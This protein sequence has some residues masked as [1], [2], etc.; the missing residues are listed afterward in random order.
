MKVNNM[1]VDKNIIVLIGLL[2][3]FYITF[4]LPNLNNRVLNLLTKPFVLL[5][6]FLITLYVANISLPIGILLIIAITTL[7]HFRNQRAL[8]IESYD[9]SIENF[10]SGYDSKLYKHEKICDIS[11]TDIDSTTILKP[12]DAF[13]KINQANI[14]NF[15][16][17]KNIVKEIKLCSQIKL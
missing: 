10:I 16:S 6:L 14:N 9:N 4:V 7:I 5:I 8:Q 17:V 12:E 3:I 2:I 11:P 15:D 1:K 13:L